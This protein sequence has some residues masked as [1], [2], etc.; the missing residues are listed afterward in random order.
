MRLQI[1][2]SGMIASDPY[3][4]GATWAVLQYVLGLRALGHR[5]MLVEP[6]RPQSLR[7]HDV[8]LEDSMNAAYF[9]SVVHEFGLDTDAAL[10]CTTSQSTIG[11]S[12]QQL[13]EFGRSADLLINISGMLAD[14]RICGHIPVKAYLDLDPAFIQCWHE[15]GLDMGFSRHTHF[16]TIG[17]AIGAPDCPIPTCGLN[18]IKTL[19]PVVL[20]HWPVATSIQR[21]AL[22]TIGNWRGYG[23]VEHR[24]V[25][26][27]Q[28]AH[29]LRPLFQLPQQTCEEFQ[30]AMSIHP[31]DS[32]DLTALRT[33]GWELID[34]AV[35]AATPQQYRTF[36]QGSK[37]EFGIAKSG[38]VH[39]G[40]GWFSDRS[41]CYL[42]SGRPVIGQDTG[43]SRGL[44][45]G[46]G[47]FAFTDADDVISAIDRLNTDY[48]HHCRAARTLA[49]EYFASERVLSKLLDRLGAAQ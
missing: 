38:Y 2:F 17:M 46:D 6:V 27:G 3:Q 36:I 25:H 45:G 41:V 16:V 28:K 34:P 24:G 1:L 37:A 9:R 23:S 49:E 32:A 15:Q 19:Q 10:F 5:V 31:G 40:S 14:E 43:F 13:V 7:P 21:N 11:P 30:L 22:T 12:Y 8:R 39:S 26:Y 4:G 33:W 42:A 35:V 48:T 18:W 44:P 20:Q 47:L 29:S